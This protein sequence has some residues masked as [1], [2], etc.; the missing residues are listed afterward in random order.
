MVG[1]ERKHLLFSQVSDTGLSAAAHG[2]SSPPTLRSAECV[3]PTHLQLPGLLL[4][5]KD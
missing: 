5:E 4:S 1:K 3:A 2:L